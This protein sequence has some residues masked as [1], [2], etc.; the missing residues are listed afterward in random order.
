VGKKSQGFKTNSLALKEALMYSSKKVI[1]VSKTFFLATLKK[2]QN[3]LERL[4]LTCIFNL[5]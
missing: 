3:K 5:A 2:R 4:T 1:G